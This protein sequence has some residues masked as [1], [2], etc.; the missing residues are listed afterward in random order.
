VDADT[1]IITGEKKRAG[2]S[3]AKWP[4]LDACQAVLNDRRD[5]WP[6]S[7]RQVHYAL[8]NDP[9]LIHAGKPDSLYA[10]DKKSYQA[11]IDI[12]TRGRL[13]G[14]I[15]WG[16]IDDTTRTV[17]CWSVHREPGTFISRE[18]GEFLKGYY[19]D[20]MQSQPNQIEIVGEKNTIESVV[21]GVAMDYRIPYTI[22]RGYASLPPRRAMAKRFEQSGKERLILLVLSDFD[23]EGEDI[24]HAFARSMRDD[25][26]IEGI[27]T[28]KVVLR[29]DQVQALGLP[30]NFEAKKKG[31]GARYASFAARYGDTTH[32]L[33]AVQP[34]QLQAFLRE[35]IDSVIDVE[36]FNHEVEAEKRDAA[37]LEGFRRYV[38][39]ALKGAHFED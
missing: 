8:L 9:P 15:S 33:E 36:R 29:H 26:G 22:G 23:P 6:L 35:S 21:R 11:V 27:E 37:R 20:L 31:G 17:V 25:F 7:V 39:E 32:E 4:F 16:A 10:N 28:I 12:L 13:A 1:I 18:V 3:K 19:R 5:F 38:H 34:A 2:I 24:P 14:H 30:D